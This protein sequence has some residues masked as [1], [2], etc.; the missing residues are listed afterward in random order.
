MMKLT[1]KNSKYLYILMFL[2]FVVGGLAWEVLERILV[3]GG[4]DIN[5]NVG[6]IGFDLDIISFYMNV[7]PGTFLGIIGS[8]FLFKGI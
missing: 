2:G 4:I 8:I 3:K 6:P 5:Y 7:N 1:R